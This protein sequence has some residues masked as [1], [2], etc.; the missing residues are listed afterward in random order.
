[1]ASGKSNIV[2]KFWVIFI[3]GIISIYG[4][5]SGI[6]VAGEYGGYILNFRD[7]GAMVAGILGGP[8]VGFFAALIGGLYRLSLGGVTAV[9]CFIATLLA[10]VLSGYAIRSW[11]GKFT[12]RRA[13]YIAAV[14]ELLHLL[15]IF[16]VYVLAN[17]TM[18]FVMIQ[19]VII[20]TILPMTIVNS[21]GLMI[22]AH[23]SQKFPLLQSG[24]KKMTPKSVAAEIKSL[25]HHDTEE[26]K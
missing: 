2:D 24:L 23:F 9:P 22:F 20:T 8:V 12:M 14:V 21:A 17:G 13:V 10:G 3:F 7:L 1:M 19:D 25:L 4:T 11:K 18:N 6:T 15:V 5:Y 26:N 16:P